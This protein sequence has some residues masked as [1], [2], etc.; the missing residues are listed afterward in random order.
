[1]TTG[2][3]KE[4]DSST[5]DSPK[6]HETKDCVYQL[7]LLPSS[8]ELTMKSRLGNPV[9]TAQTHIGQPVLGN[10]PPSF[11]IGDDQVSEPERNL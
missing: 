10:L 5:T 1:M 8:C 11:R 3:K 4:V 6:L 2:S 7:A 9:D